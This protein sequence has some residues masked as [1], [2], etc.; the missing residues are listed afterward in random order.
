MGIKALGYV[1]IETAQPQRWD[2]FLTQ[3]AGVMRAPDAADGAQLYRIDQRPF[4]FRIEPGAQDRFVAAAYEVDSDGALDALASAIAAAGQPVTPGSA[5]EAALRGVGRFFRTSDP[6]G[7]GLEFYYGNS[8]AETPFV[9]P[10]GI[11]HFITGEMGM[12]HAVFSAPNFNECVA[13]YRDVVGFHETDMPRF[14]FG[15][16]GPDDPGMGFAFMHADNGRH[17]S[18][19]LG[20][21]PVPP[22]GC[23]H[24]MLELPSLVEVGK[25]YDRMKAMGYPE[26]A[27]LGQHYNDETVG[28]YVQTPGGFDLEIGCDSLVIDPASW[29]V[30]RHKGISIWGHEW[31]WQK[32]MKEQQAAAE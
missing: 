9:S 8:T 28:F 22:S 19:A 12:G 20:E 16:G 10:L 27:S 2:H 25:A 29:E 1:V 32:A 23:V 4:R 26:S 21:G 3:L 24:L 6:A 5:V 17:H 18:I 30:T 13:F 7:N 31:A 11:S 14:F 15:G